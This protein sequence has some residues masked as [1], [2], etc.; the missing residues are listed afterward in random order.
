MAFPELDMESLGRIASEFDFE[1]AP[2]DIFYGPVKRIG[3]RLNRIEYVLATA[4]AYLVI[5]VSWKVFLDRKKVWSLIMFLGCGK[6][7]I[8]R[9][10]EEKSIYWYFCEHVGQEAKGPLFFWSYIYYLSK[11]YELLD[12]FVALLRGKPPPSFKM[13]IYHHSV[14]MFMTWFWLAYSQG[15]KEI[16][17][18]SW[19]TRI[20]IIQF[21]FSMMCVV[22]WA[23]LVFGY[24]RQCSGYHA[25]LFNLGFNASLL[26][27]FLGVLTRIKEDKKKEN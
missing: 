6:C 20:Q 5:V 25:T 19:I 22:P 9:V 8:D 26:F 12:T 3:F 11:Y 17:W 15:V 2:G 21:V 10:L 7:F 18:K 27:L 23:V 1:K 24:K 13:H 4:T 14:V 16:W